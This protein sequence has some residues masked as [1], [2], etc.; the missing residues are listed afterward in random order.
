MAVGDVNGDELHDV[1]LCQ[2]GGLSNQLL[3]QRP[4]G[5]LRDVSAASGTDW[6]DRSR[7]ALLIDLD[8][9]GD[10]DLVVGLGPAIVL[11]ENDGSGTFIQ[12]ANLVTETDPLSLAAADYDL[13]G[14]LDVYACFYSPDES[15]DARFPQPVPQHDANNG[16]RNR[17][18]RNDGDWKFSDV[19]K[20][21]G[22]DANNKRWSLA[23]AWEDID[24]DGDPDL[25]VANDFGPNAMYKNEAGRFTEVT[26][27]TGTKDAAFGMS[28]SF[29]DVDRDGRMD[30]YINMYSYAGN[31][32]SGQARFLSKGQEPLRQALGRLAVGNTLLTAGAN[33]RFDNVST[34][35][36]VN[37]GGWA[38]SSR[39]ADLN[40]EGW[41]DLLTVNGYVT[42]ELPDNL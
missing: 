41:L 13:D 3:V 29:G 21:A 37:R 2:S 20:D 42:G 12:R 11:M 5:T 33:G 34:A 38:W 39:F 35:R 8:N 18:Y 15:N 32:V 40:N 28:V 25:Y 6:L 30:L 19:T 9:D 23:A 24:N 22:L 7:S 27:T 10:A 31:R 16:G 26:E 1:Y 17:L 4:D 36:G 14:D